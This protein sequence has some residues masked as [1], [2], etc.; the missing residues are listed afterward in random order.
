MQNHLHL[1]SEYAGVGGEGGILQM[2]L[3]NLLNTNVWCFPNRVD[4]ITLLSSL[5]I[6]SNKIED[7]YMNVE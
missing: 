2:I 6:I 1:I 5:L 4:V 3:L 7:E